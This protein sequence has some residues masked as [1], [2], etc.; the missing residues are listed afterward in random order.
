MTPAAFPL[1]QRLSTRDGEM[2]APRFDRY[3]GLSLDVYGEYSPAERRAL[4]ALVAP[5]DT[6]VQCGANIGALTVPL[7]RAVGPLGRVLAFEPQ[8]LCYRALVANTC[9][10]GQLHIEPIR[11]A[12]GAVSGVAS[13]PLVNYAAPGNFGGVSLSPE[14]TASRVRLVTLDEA[15][16]EVSRCRLLQLDVEG[17]EMDVLAGAARFIARTRPILCIEVDRPD[18]RQALGPWLAEQRYE[19]MEH[20]PALYAS[21]NWRSCETN[22]FADSAGQS[23]ASFNALAW[24][25]E[26]EERQH[27]PPDVV[28]FAP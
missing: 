19:V 28:P 18:V 5:G 26:R 6:V 1:L 8:E 15:L 2:M 16:Q 23:L 25:S 9:L 21:D 13:L 17:A 11:A 10:T 20:R 22:V 24:P 7:A 3:V 27:L 12:V 14:P 4:C